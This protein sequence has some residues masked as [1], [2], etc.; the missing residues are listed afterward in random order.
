MAVRIRLTRK[1]KKKQPTYR[2]IVADGRSPRDG[3]YIEQIGRYD[4]RQE[5]SIV[6]IDND[7][8][9]YWLSVG[10]QPSDAVRK[11]LEI[12]GA[13]EARPVKIKD[14]KVHVV[15]EAAQIED[16]EDDAAVI[17]AVEVAADAA[18]TDDVA[19][20]D[21]PAEAVVANDAGESAEDDTG[22]DD[23]LLDKAKDA[24][25]AAVEKVADVVEDVVEKVTGDDGE[26]ES[27]EESS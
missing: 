1:G 14:A 24:V 3:R 25:A 21:E 11:L 26:E 16:A 18:T 15:D 2:V 23:S 20:V 5:P 8:A 9:A 12:S 17:E 4:P 22:D 10:A 13:L 6:V 27:E 19:T 7:R